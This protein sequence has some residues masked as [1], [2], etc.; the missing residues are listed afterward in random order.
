MCLISFS[1]GTLSTNALLNNRPT[2][3]C[4]SGRSRPMARRG[5]EQLLWLVHYHQSC[6]HATFD[7]NNGHNRW[8]WGSYVNYRDS[9]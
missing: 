6:A 8:C 5:D 4:R 1:S 7:R 2:L 9:N 3:C